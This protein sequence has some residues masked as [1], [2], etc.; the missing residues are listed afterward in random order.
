[1]VRNQTPNQTRNPLNNQPLRQLNNTS[2]P[3][4]RTSNSSPVNVNS[5][6]FPSVASNL[7]NVPPTVQTSINSGNATA[8]QA[9]NITFSP[10][11]S[12]K[13]SAISQTAVSQLVRKELEK[14]LAQIEFP[15]PP[16]QDI[17]FLP[18]TNNSEFLMCLGLEEVAKCVQEHLIH[19]QLKAEIKA[20]AQ[21]VAT[22]ENDSE[23]SKP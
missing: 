21:I 17:Y 9:G 13:V 19:K 4:N 16:A 15:K 23:V 7:S 12:E 6:N 2:S 3:A 18:N 10:K 8:S 5:K 1:M 11:V 14:S 22:K 20:E